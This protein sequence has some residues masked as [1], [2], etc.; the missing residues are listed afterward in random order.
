[1]RGKELLD[2]ME[3]IEPGYVEAAELAPAKRKRETPLWIRFGAIAACICLLLAL[4]AVL[5]HRAER[6]AS[7]AESNDGPSSFE[8]DGARYV[9]SPHIFVTDTLPEGFSLGGKTDVGGYEDCPYYVNPNMPE[10]VYVYQEVRT[11]GQVD[12]TGTLVSTGPHD[13]YLRY[14]HEDLRG[15]DLVCYGDSYYISMWS[16]TPYGDRPDVSLEYYDAMESR[17]GIRIEGNV[18]ESFCLVGTAEFTGHDSIPRG[19]LACN[20]GELDIYANP[21]EPDVIYVSSSWHTASGRHEGFDV[22]IRYDFPL[23]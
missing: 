9:I 11:N 19:E 21:D 12:S 18:P 2:K 4:P 6:P 16:A 5:S 14:V 1:M 22:Y 23:A 7:P 8:V 10:W 17:Y 15:R 13:A 3:L 20:N